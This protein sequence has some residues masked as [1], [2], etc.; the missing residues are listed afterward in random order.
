[1]PPAS[2]RRSSSARSPAA[3]PRRIA[4]QVIRVGRVTLIDDTYNASPPSVT[5]ALDLLA[6]LPGRRVAVLGEML[7]LGKGAATGH[8]D[9]GTAAAADLR[10]ARGRRRRAPRDRRRRE[11]GRPRRRRGSSRRAIATRRSTCC[12]AGSATATS[13]S[14]RRPA[15]SSSTC[16]ST[17]FAPSWPRHAPDERPADPGG[18]ARLRGHGDHHARVH[19]LVRYIGMGKQILV[20]GPESPPGEGRHADDGRPPDHRR[21]HRP[22]LLHSGGLPPGGIIAP[23]ATLLL[24]G[25]LGAFDDYLNA[26]TGEGI[27][28][29]Q[30]M[31]WL[32]VVAV[33]A[34]YQIQTRTRS[35]RSPSRSSA[36]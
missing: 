34:A 9:V 33:V 18:P 26:R 15:A 22:V 16:S 8:R 6:G 32:V 4:G 20:E 31:L 11:G 24:V 21:G 29:R 23:L 2:S 7:E 5:A 10:P 30:K 12:A 25:G 13:S 1:M 27:S 14:S 3:G 17:R 28:A 36:R 19:P 35:T